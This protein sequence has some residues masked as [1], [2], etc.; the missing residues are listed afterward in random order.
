MEGIDFVLQL[1]APSPQ[2]RLTA[3]AALQHPWLNSPIKGDARLFTADDV[4]STRQ[5]ESVYRKSAKLNADMLQQTVENV[6]H[7]RRS[8]REKRSTVSIDKFEKKSTEFRAKRG[9]T[10][11][12]VTTIPTSAPSSALPSKKESTDKKGS[13]L[14]RNATKFDSSAIGIGPSSSAAPASRASH[15]PYQPGGVTRVPT[16]MV[17]VPIGSPVIPK[18]LKPSDAKPKGADVKA[19]PQQYA[20]APAFP[21]PTLSFSPSPALSPALLPSIEG[22]VCPPSPPKFAAPSAPILGK[23]DDTSR[24][25]KRKGMRY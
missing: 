11:I 10:L 19:N 4:S 16:G 2:S 15:S 5:R 7:I 8:H 20:D 25:S 3:A 23:E 24:S 1:L 18:G 9:A 14:K 12:D 6:D 13:R 22:D 17:N 21:S